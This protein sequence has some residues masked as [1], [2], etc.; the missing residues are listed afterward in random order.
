M[1]TG[2]VVLNFNDAKETVS[3]VEK[4]KSYNILDSIVVVD[5]AST[6]DSLTDVK[7]KESI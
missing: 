1:K 5:N 7:Y 2:I 6:D 3:F 4:I